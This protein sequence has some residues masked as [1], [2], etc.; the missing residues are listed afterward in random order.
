MHK[1]TEYENLKPGTLLRVKKHCRQNKLVQENGIFAIIAPKAGT[2]S[3]S[4]L[5]DLISPSGQ[6][7]IF[8][9]MNWEVVSDVK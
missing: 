6:R 9:P 8:V 2:T 7:C 5:W 4:M 1:G 3:T